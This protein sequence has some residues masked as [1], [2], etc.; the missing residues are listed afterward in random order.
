MGNIYCVISMNCWSWIGNNLNTVVV[1]PRTLVQQ[2]FACPSFHETKTSSTFTR[3]WQIPRLVALRGKA[4]LPPQ[5]LNTCGFCKNLND[6]WGVHEQIRFKGKTR[7]THSW[8]LSGFEFCAGNLWAMTPF[9]IVN[10][11]KLRTCHMCIL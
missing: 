4:C 7:L 10:Y 1:K 2:V 5:V 3:P 11:S 8:K 9:L 6:S